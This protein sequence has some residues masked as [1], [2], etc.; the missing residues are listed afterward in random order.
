MKLS[1]ESLTQVEV[2]DF[3][4]TTDAIAGLLDRCGTMRS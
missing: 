2:L 4:S 1:K 3:G